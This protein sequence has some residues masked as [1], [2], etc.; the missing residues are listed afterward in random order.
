[1]LHTW[2]GATKIFSSFFSHLFSLSFSFSILL[3][4]NNIA[5]YQPSDTAIAVM[6]VVA[7]EAKAQRKSHCR[8]KGS[9]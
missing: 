3:S 2:S 7:E 5:K 6:I 1:M 8:L 9:L 4:E